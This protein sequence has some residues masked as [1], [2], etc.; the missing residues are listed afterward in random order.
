MRILV[1]AL[2]IS[3]SACVNA[4]GAADQP[5]PFAAAAAPATASTDY[6]I[7]IDLPAGAYVVD[8]RHTSVIFR[9]RHQG[10]A[11]FTARFGIVDAGMHLD[12]ADPSRSVISASV[13]ANSVDTGILNADGERRFDAEIARAL[14]AEANPQITFISS[15]VTRTG[16]NTA[17]VTGDLTMN[18]QTHPTT[19]DVV[20]AGGFTDPVR[21][22]TVIG[23]SATTTIQRSQW[24]A[25]TWGAFVGDDVQI[26]IEAEF[27]KAAS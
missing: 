14:G 13:D 19:F 9:V 16:Q 10:L 1:M 24:G 20:Y 3:L 18:G 7:A 22:R 21:M 15:A 26:V 5:A 12:P 17:R 6:P 23:F 8:K 11:W 27:L 2:A 25:T 4:P